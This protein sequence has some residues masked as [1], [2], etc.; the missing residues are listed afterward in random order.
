MLR[1]AE[2]QMRVRATADVEGLRVREHIFVAVRRRIEHH[3]LFAG[4]DLGTAQLGVG[5]RGAPEVVQRV[6]VAQDL[7]D[8][9]ADERRIGAQGGELVGMIEE[10]PQAG[11]QHC[12]GGVVAHGHE[13]H[14]EAAE[15]EVAHVGAVEVG[16]EQQRREVHAGL[17][18]AAGG[19]E[20]DRVQSHVDRA[21]RHV[22]GVVGVLA[23][24]VHLREPVD[25]RQVRLGQAHELTDDTRRQGGGDVVHELDV[26]AF[27]GLGHDLPADGADLTFHVRDHT[28]LEPRGDGAAVVDVAGRVHRQQHVAHHLEL[29]LLEV[30]EHHPALARREELGLARHVH[31]VGVLQHHP[32]TGFAC[33]LLEV[34]GL[35]PPELGEDLVRWRRDVGVGIVEI[36]GDH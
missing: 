1:D 11:R 6:L 8:R 29:R 26:L 25:E 22:G 7:L 2:R 13:L 16:L 5:R 19:R 32:I 14:E 17:L 33:H 21:L 31:E 9:T 20:L 23:A 12:L 36:D 24:R 27:R 30:L 18:G 35:R 15:V 10:R 4:R 3:D 28:S 34:D